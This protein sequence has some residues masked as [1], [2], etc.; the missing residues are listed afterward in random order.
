MSPVASIPAD[1]SIAVGAEVVLFALNLDVP[2][3]AFGFEKRLGKMRHG[4]ALRADG[5]EGPQSPGGAWR[6][7]GGSL[8]GQDS[9][10]NDAREMTTRRKSLSIL[11][12][13]AGI[14]PAT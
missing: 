12:D 3:A 4:K 6:L 2:N 11:V 7:A 14:E 13:R 8:F 5:S 10:T 1:V 9:R